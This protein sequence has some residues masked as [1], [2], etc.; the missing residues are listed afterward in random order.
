MNGKTINGHTFKEIGDL[1]KAPFNES[2]IRQ[3]DDTGSFYFPTESFK[4]RFDAVVG[5]MN[6][7]YEI[8]SVSRIESVG[9][10]KKCIIEV[11]VAITIKSDDGEPVKRCEG[12]G[13]AQMIIVSSTGTEK[14]PNGD[15]VK[16]EQNAFKHLCQNVFGMANEQ[17]SDMNDFG[18]KKGNNVYSSKKN[19]DYESDIS[20]GEIPKG[21][22]KEKLKITSPFVQRGGNVYGKAASNH[23]NDCD[24]VI[25]QKDLGS[26]TNKMPLQTFIETYSV[27]TELPLCGTYGKYNGRL[28]FK[29][30]P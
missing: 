20:D 9:S 22:I 30:K 7:D 27:G 21:V 13:A 18:K 8:K 16:A 29:Y 3:R 6:Y 11:C 15:V 25:F 23:S 4:N 2:E 5:V 1:L 26:I 10:G 19:N 24:I 14:N 17:L 28:Q 12:I